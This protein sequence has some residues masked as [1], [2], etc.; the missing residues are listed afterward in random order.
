MKYILYVSACVCLFV[1]LVYISILVDGNDQYYINNVANTFEWKKSID[2]YFPNKKID[3]T[4]EV[5]EEK[6]KK[7]FPVSRRVPNAE[8]LGPN[9]LSEI[10]FGPTTSE[11]KNGYYTE[12][13][14]GL[15]LEKFEVKNKI[16]YISFNK[17]PSLFSKDECRQERAYTQIVKT[18][19]NLPDID[20]VVIE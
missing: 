14:Q 4:L 16:A 3:S 7:V 12:I 2:I 20:E 1:F 11:Q 18:L 13:N 8:T 9:A 17:N 6:C 19:Q 15:L 5:N 10:I